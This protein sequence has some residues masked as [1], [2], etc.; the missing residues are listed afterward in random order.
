MGEQRN[1]LTYRDAGVDID[2]G[3]NLVERIKPAAAA[4]NRAG[5]LGGLGGFGALF[6]LK[7]A[8]FRDPILVTTTDGVGTK[9]KIAIECGEHKTIGIDLVAMCVNDLVVQGAEPLLF[10]DYFATGALHVETAAT[11]ISGIAEGCRMAGCALVGG[12]T[13]EMPG[14][15]GKGDYDLA[16]FAVGAVERERILPRGD[17][18]AGDVILGLASSGVHSNGYS[19]VRRV[20]EMSGLRWSDPAP[21]SPGASLGTALLTP[22]RIYVRSCLAA[23]RE[24]SGVKALAHITGGGLVENIPRV[25]PKHLAAEI[26]LGAINAP[27]VFRWLSRPVAEAEMLRTFNCGIGMMLVVDPA[28]ESEVRKVLE[29]AGESVTA[30]GHMAAREKSAVVFCGKLNLDD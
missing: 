24:T 8:G 14:L 1:T 29:A 27:A 18:A 26:D 11:V 3:N 23:I 22:T 16:G 30:L 17:V 28:Q 13:A 6:D 2:A 7:A 12:E 9:L 20:A 21:F 15:Y 19:L 10:L 4:T 5:T 25:I